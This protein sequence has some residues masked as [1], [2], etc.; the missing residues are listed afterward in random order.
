MYSI[1][2]VWN[3]TSLECI[4]NSAYKLAN[5][6]VLEVHCSRFYTHL[7]IYHYIMHCHDSQMYPVS[8]LF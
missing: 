4:C 5:M 8:H 3:Y 2:N 6:R 1:L 7:C